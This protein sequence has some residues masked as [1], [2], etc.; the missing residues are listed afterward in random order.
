MRSG[1]SHWHNVTLTNSNELSDA[2]F[3]ELATMNKRCLGILLFALLSGPSASAATVLNVVGG[4]LLGASRVDVGG[5]L[6][7]V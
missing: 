5:V 1:S 6:Y 4:Q 7:D 2:T 3:W